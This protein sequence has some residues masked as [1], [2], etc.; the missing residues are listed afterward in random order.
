M[1]A[2]TRYRNQRSQLVAVEEIT[3]FR[4]TPTNDDEGTTKR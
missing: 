4:Y 3:V 2:E 1:T